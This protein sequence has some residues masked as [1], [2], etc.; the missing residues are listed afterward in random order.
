MPAAQLPN[1]AGECADARLA[2][3]LSYDYVYNT[4][5]VA[6]G[7]NPSLPEVGGREGGNG[8]GQLA[9]LLRPGGEV[10]ASACFLLRAGH[11]FAVQ[12]DSF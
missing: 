6:Y 11:N 12:D 4:S 1:T 2:L 3:E 8:G 7:Y 10:A 5:F 9:L